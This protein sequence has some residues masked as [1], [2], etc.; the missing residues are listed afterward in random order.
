[1]THLLQKEVACP[2]AN[3]SQ[4]IGALKGLALDIST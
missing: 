2:E 3:V 1:M 4:E